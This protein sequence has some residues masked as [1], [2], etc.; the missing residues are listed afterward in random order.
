MQLPSE[1]PVMTLS[2]VILFPQAML[3]LYIFEPRYRKM[4]ADV[5]AGDRLMAV[6]MRR[7]DSQRE[8]P[9][10]V[11]GLGLVRVCVTRPDGTSNL[12]LQGLARLKLGKATRYR[13]YRMHQAEPLPPADDSSLVVQALTARI[14]ELVRERLKHGLEQAVKKLPTGDKDEA[15]TGSVTL[16]AFQE[17]LQHLAKLDDAEQL[18]DLVSAALLREPRQRQT[19]LETPHLEERLRHLVRFL[20]RDTGTEISD[21]SA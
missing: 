20:Q 21:D 17:A 16:E 8:Q 9:V 10:N 1:V 18:A 2:N 4:L 15:E 13:P 19:I 6:A 7:N 3:P 11:A 5:L 12:V 14:L